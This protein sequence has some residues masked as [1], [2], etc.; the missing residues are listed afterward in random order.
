MGGEEKLLKS[1]GLWE[2]W[3]NTR[4]PEPGVIALT[5]GGGKT[6][7]MENL[8]AEAAQAGRR[9]LAATSTHIALPDRGTVLLFLQDCGMLE[10]RKD[11]EKRRYPA[12]ALED[13]DFADCL[14]EAGGSVLTA[15]TLCRPETAGGPEGKVIRKLTALP[16]TLRKSLMRMADVVFVEADGAKRLPLKLPAAHEPAL[17]KETEAVICC[18]GLSALGRRAG[19]AVFRRELFSLK[20]N[21]PVTEEL[22]GRILASERGGR[23]HVGALEY[24]AVL[25][26]CDTEELE[27]AAGRIG[28]FLAE[29]GIHGAAVCRGRIRLTF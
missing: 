9:A 27:A 14:F 11:R 21:E 24:R 12:A 6:T 4:A 13:P 7:T 15:G 17:E 16:E 1:L 28:A 3:G 23:K 25:N 20:E 19:E 29:R 18:A 5:G 10:L 2:R 26:Q 8:A 22:I